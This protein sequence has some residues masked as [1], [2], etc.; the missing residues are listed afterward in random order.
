LN[1]IDKN[2]PQ[3]KTAGAFFANPIYKERPVHLKKP[4]ARKL[5]LMT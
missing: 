1:K 2:L 3:K 4:L 5:A